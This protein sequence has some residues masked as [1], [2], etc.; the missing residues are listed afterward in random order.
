MKLVKESWCT[1]V[2]GSVVLRCVIQPKASRTQ[3]E[4]LFGEPPRLR[5]RVAAPPVEGAANDAL[6]LF[7]K[8]VFRVRGLR[9]ELLRGSTSRLKDFRLSGVSSQYV[10]EALA[11][12]GLEV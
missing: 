10:K 5:V 12:L 6:L 8:K 7:F 4:G 1:E 11:E 9:V 3:I 2:D